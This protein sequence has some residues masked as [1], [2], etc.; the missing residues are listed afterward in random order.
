M[1]LND[2]TIFWKQPDVTHFRSAFYGPVQACQSAQRAINNIFS[3][4]GMPATEIALRENV[5]ML[6]TI[7]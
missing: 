5:N 3:S 4:L 7:K 2:N 1:I 6:S